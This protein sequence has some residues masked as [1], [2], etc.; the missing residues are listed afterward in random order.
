MTTSSKRPITEKQKRARRE[1]GRQA[2]G[3]TSAEGK[4]RSSRNAT[5]HGL[6]ARNLRPIDAGP[7]REDPAE[8]EAFAEAYLAELNPGDSV[9]LRQAALDLIDKAWRM[10]RAQGWEAAGYSGAHDPSGH[11]QDVQWFRALAARTRREAETVRLSPD[12]RGSDDDILGALCNLAFAVGVDDDDLEWVDDAEGPAIAQGLATLITEHFGDSEGAASRLDEIAAK[13]EVEAGD[14][15]G[16]SPAEAVRQEMEGSFARNAERLVA[17]ASREYD[18]SLKR[19]WTLLD[20]YGNSGDN[21]EEHDSDFDSSH[22]G[23]AEENSDP[24]LESAPDWA[25]DELGIFS[26]YSADEVVSMLLGRS[27]VTGPEPETRN[28]PTEANS[29]M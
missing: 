7:L 2:H 22:F 23:H 5:K 28:E 6:W 20:R 18:R 10:T 3:A 19:Y 17:N 24:G 14:L 26:R 13:Y 8:L 11:D 9:I 16:S 4:D 15:E 25:D 27:G 12:A 1:N 21:N 29:S